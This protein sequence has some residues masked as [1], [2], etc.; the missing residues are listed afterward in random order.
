M[1]FLVVLVPF[2]LVL[3]FV[4]LSIMTLCKM[5][6]TFLVFYCLPLVKNFYK[7]KKITFIR[8]ISPISFFSLAKKR[9]F[10]VKGSCRSFFLPVRC[11]SKGSDESKSKEEILKGKSLL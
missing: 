9:F 6:V 5:C 7:K 8:Q 1:L 3:V 4:L 2:L 10:G 11:F